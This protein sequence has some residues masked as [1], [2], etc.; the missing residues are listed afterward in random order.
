MYPSESWQ[1]WAQWFP[2]WADKDILS[3]RKEVRRKQREVTRLL[4]AKEEEERMEMQQSSPAANATAFLKGMVK[5]LTIIGGVVELGKMIGEIPLT[6]KALRFNLN[7]LLQ[8]QKLVEQEIQIRKDR[9][10]H[11]AV[12]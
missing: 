8:V 2:C 5:G 1:E 3:L 6:V 11:P 12:H 7:K 10:S 4:A 9:E